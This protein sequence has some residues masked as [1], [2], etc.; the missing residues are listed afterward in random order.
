MI[1][2]SGIGYIT[3]EAK[4]SRLTPKRRPRTLPAG[5]SNVSRVGVRLNHWANPEEFRPD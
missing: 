5:E 2:Q 3:V 4:R 1:L